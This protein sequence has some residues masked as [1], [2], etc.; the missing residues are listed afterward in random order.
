[1]VDEYLATGVEARAGAGLLTG[2]YACYDTYATADGEWVAVGAIEASFFA[3][4]CRALGCDALADRQFDDDAQEEIRRTF[5]TAFG[6]DAR[7]M[8]GQAGRCGH[9]RGPG[10]LDRRG[11]GRSRG[12]GAGRHPPGRWADPPASARCWPACPL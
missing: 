2:R 5:A 6:G 7:R 1:M 4:L 3:N 10:A 9:L 11:G 8:G 12:A